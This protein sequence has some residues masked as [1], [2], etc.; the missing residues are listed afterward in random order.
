MAQNYSNQVVVVTGASAGIGAALAGEVSRRGAQV[1][2]AA[3]R[4]EQL[5]AVAGGLKGES[6]CVQTD[7]TDK[8]QVQRLFSRAVERFGRVDVWVNNAGRGI[9]RSLEEL[10]DTDLDTM[11]RDNVKPALFGMQAVL[12][13]FR[14][15]G[16]GTLANVSSMLGRMPFAPFRCAYSASKAALD[17]LTE[18]ARLEYAK[19][20]PKVRWVVVYPGVVYTDFGNNALFGGPDS[21]SIPGGQTAEEVARV[22]ADGLLEGP[23]DLYTRPEAVEGVLEYVRR[24][25]QRP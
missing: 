10:G 16:T 24:G 18:N 15:R 6:L 11:V 20:L 21:R 5:Q 23:L 13:H 22:V 2:L 7:V 12:P 14:A 17:S 1:V 8:A 19:S 9:S 4:Q 25:A 3:R